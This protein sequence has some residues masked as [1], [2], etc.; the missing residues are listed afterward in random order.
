MKNPYGKTVKKENAYAVYGNDP[1]LPGWTWYILKLNQSPEKAKANPSASAFCLV[2]SPMTGSSGDMGDTYLND[3]GGVLISGDDILSATGRKGHQKMK[4]Q[5][6]EQ[7]GEIG[8]DAGLCWIGDPCYVLHPDVAPKAIGKNWKEFCQRLD[9]EQY[10]IA[11]QFNYD[12]GHA[13]LGV[14][15]STGYGD[16]TY[17]VEIRRDEDGRIAEV[18]VKFLGD[19]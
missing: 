13:G 19:D 8:V 9:G 14:C 5:K 15:V 17:P 4:D 1:R 10:P 7:V 6:W 16:G 18:R 2:T 3:I 11:K 12:L